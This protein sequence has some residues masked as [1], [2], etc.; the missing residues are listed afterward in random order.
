MYTEVL[1]LSEN[2]EGVDYYVG[3]LHG[4]YSLLMAEL[5]KVG[6]N[7]QKDRLICAGDLVDRGPENKQCIELLV[8]PWFFSAIG[9]HDWM[10]ILYTQGLFDEDEFFKN[11]GSWTE[12]L[13]ANEMESLSSL[14]L[15]RLHLGIEVEEDGLPTVGVFHSSIPFGE[16]DS[17]EDRYSPFNMLTKS[18]DW[19]L[20]SDITAENLMPALFARATYY[21]PV[22]NIPLVVHGHTVTSK[23]WD[24]NTLDAFKVHNIVYIDTGMVFYGVAC[25]FRKEKTSTGHTLTLV[26]EPARLE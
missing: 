19:S 13:S 18:P 10:F 16:E 9:N 24:A 15:E 3:D 23:L 20:V 14:M 5:K 4:S 25:L 2:T 8:Q 11:G 21:E 12:C 7:F 22:K 1:T 17:P 26:G 6:F